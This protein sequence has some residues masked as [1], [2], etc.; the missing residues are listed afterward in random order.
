MRKT[1][2]TIDDNA[3]VAL[4]KQGHDAAFNELTR[5]HTKTLR[6]VIGTVVKEPCFVDD[7][8]Q[9]TFFNAL[10]SINLYKEEGPFIAWLSAIARNESINHYR[11]V[12]KRRC[13]AP[14]DIAELIDD[15]QLS[16]HGE[17]IFSEKERCA[18]LRAL[19]E[20]LP[21]SMKR[22]IVLYYHYGLSFPE[23]AKRMGADAKAVTYRSLADRA[24]DCMR[25]MIET[26]SPELKL[27]LAK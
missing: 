9:N 17:K 19:I 4:F 26:G 22:V 14:C 16:V 1:L 5:R 27:I 12:K 11:L 18:V 7:V 23:I 25:K 15:E 8:L 3:L 10:R 13:V 21:F 24:R 2:T 20:Q 6:A